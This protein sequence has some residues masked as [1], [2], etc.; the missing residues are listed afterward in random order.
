MGFAQFPNPVL[1]ARD[2]LIVGLGSAVAWAM[3]S[4]CSSASWSNWFNLFAAVFA[5]LAVG[6]GTH[7]DTLCARASSSTDDTIVWE[8][9]SLALELPCRLRAAGSPTL[10]DKWNA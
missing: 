6:Y 1:G 8:G 3:A 4:A 9:R 5:A 7:G 2:G 10:Q